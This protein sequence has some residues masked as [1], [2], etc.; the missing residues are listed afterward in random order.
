MKL[1]L[2]AFLNLSFKIGKVISV[3][4]LFFTL[5]VIIAC[6][7]SFIPLTSAKV[8]TPSFKIIEQMFEGNSSS[9]VTQ[10]N[11][12]SND[13]KVATDRY[14]KEIE[15]I[16]KKNNLN[17][18]MIPLVKQSIQN[19]PAKYVKQYLRGLDKFCRDG[20]SYLEDHRYSMEN[21]ILVNV[22]K[23]LGYYYQNE[24]YNAIHNIKK[25]GVYNYYVSK[26]LVTE[27]DFY[28]TQN[29]V[30]SD[31]QSQ[32]NTITL[33]SVGCVLGVSLLVFTILLFLPILIKIEENTR[34][35]VTKTI[36]DNPQPISPVE[37]ESVEHNIQPTPADDE[38]FCPNCNRIIKKT[39]KKC[40]FCNTW[41]DESIG[42]NE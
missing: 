6:G 7:L 19:I 18:S 35:G 27:Y 21:F 3:V 22:K 28:F 39:A 20:L 36:T 32:T 34:G 26:G 9:N 33:I 12:V 2:D 30:A 1:G 42:G 4:L 31:E 23:E 29:L 24:Y 10:G 13:S 38:K 25:Q 5:F 15:R 14:D 11:S 17:T 16:I 37:S 8:D 40:R 41:L